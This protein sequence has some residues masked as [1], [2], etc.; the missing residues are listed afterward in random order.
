MDNRLFGNSRNKSKNSRNFGRKYE[1]MSSRRRGIFQ[2]N[3]LS[4][5]LFVVCLFP[6]THILRDTALGYHFASNGQIVNYLLFMDDLKL[7]ASN[8]KS[9]ESL[10]QTVRVMT[11]GWSEKMCSIGNEERKDGQ[12]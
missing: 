7:Y 1:I 6:L 3:S 9:Y 2:G 11:Y 5:F 10:I 8:G 4:P 12:L